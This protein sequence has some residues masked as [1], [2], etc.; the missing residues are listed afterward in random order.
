MEASIENKLAF[1]Y[2]INK[3]KLCPVVNNHSLSIVETDEIIIPKD[4]L[5]YFSKLTQGNEAAEFTVLILIYNVLI[6]RYFESS[7]FVASSGLLENG[8][9]LLYK[10]NP[11]KDKTLKQCLIEFKEEVQEVLKYSNIEE[12][13]VTEQ[14]FDAYTPYGFSFN[15]NYRN[16]KKNFPFFLN[17]ANLEK[18][19]TISLCYDRSFT[20]EYTAN[21][22]LRNIETWLLDLEDYL[23]Q[24]AIKLPIITKDERSQILDIFNNTSV[25]ISN[26]KTIV[27]LF[28][29]QVKKTPDNIAVVF[30]EKTLT[31]SELNG[32]SNQF[33][34]YIRET[35]APES[36]DLIGIKLER[37]EQLLIVILGILKS[38]AAYVPIDI[39]YPS[40]R[41][42]YIQQDSQ[43]K[44]IVDEEKLNYFR[45]IKD[46]YDN[47]NLQNNTGP[48]HLAY[49]IYTSGTTGNPKGVMIMHKNATALLCW[50]HDEF[51]SEKFD[52]VYA[53]TSHCFDLSIYEMFYPLSIGKKIKV[54]QNALEIGSELQHDK[55]VLINSVPSSISNLIEEGSGLNDVA[56]FN[57]AG[58]VFPLELAQTLLS[59]TN[60]EIRNLYG[61]SE[62]TTYSTCYK[63][64]PNKEYNYSIPIGKP[65]DNTKAFILDEAL[66]LR[67]IGLVGKLYLSGS[68]ITKGYLNKTELTDSKYISNPFLNGDIMYD[69]GDLAR[70]TPEGD[71]E[72]LGRKDNQVKIR[73]YRIELE[74]IETKLNLIE[75]I[76]QVVVITKKDT[77]SNSDLLLAFYK[78]RE[79]LDSIKLRNELKETLPDYMIPSKFIKLD[80]FPLNVNKKIDRNALTRLDINAHSEKAAFSPRSD[81]E[82]RLASIWNKVLGIDGVNIND[83]F[84]D[85]GGNGLN[86]TKLINEIQKE[87]NIEVTTKKIFEFTTFKRQVSYIENVKIIGEN[88][89]N[90]NQETEKFII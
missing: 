3:L 83:D 19:L 44:D 85:L 53:S 86:V 80:T 45:S 16:K 46:Q 41:I 10:I 35:Y 78:S 5:S 77:T 54:L 62:D 67:P 30:E 33:A 75:N 38:G 22:V 25:S 73:G 50:A 90:Y 12:G 1:N 21:H 26:D 36:D 43:C 15:G 87:F 31:Y 7:L 4:Q 27:D 84:L 39:N 18:G 56:F 69:T 48:D 2:W 72:F 11:V 59:T 61:P 68:G 74:E 88:G 40:D 23:K 71:M 65:I 47:I 28:E 24:D 8:E 32:Q 6:Q 17:I 66:E 81:I 64:S 14:S 20:T 70:W 52:V 76:Q 60:A 37:S 13:L 63:L 58:E 29:E 79:V 34:R 57:L 89:S 9:T 49:V 82:L 42:K 51:D 55:K